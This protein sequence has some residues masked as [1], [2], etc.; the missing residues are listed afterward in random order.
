MNDN[1]ETRSWNQLAAENKELRKQVADYEHAQAIAEAMA[2]NND[3]L[4]SAD[5]IENRLL[6]RARRRN[7]E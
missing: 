4:R 5:E 7:R 2:A 6:E 3:V 1:E